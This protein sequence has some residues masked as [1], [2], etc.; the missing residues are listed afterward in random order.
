[1]TYTHDQQ[2]Q[3]ARRVLWEID[4]GNPAGRQFVGE[5]M[6]R[7]GLP[8]EAIVQMVNRVAHESHSLDTVTPTEASVA[9]FFR[10]HAGR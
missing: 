8:A 7:T 10:R 1:M 9:S 3:M 2:V 4:Q 6:V 5:C